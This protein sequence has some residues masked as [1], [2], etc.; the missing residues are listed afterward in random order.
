MAK[1]RKFE[2]YGLY[3]VCG[4]SPY[5]PVMYV[6]QASMG[7]RD[8]FNKH[9]YAARNDAS[10]PVSRWMRKHGVENIRYTVL[11][12]VDTGEEMDIAEE[13]WIERLGTLISEGGYNIIPGG[14]GVRG[15]THA[16]WAKSR[17]SREPTQETK[18]KIAATLRGKFTGEEAANVKTTRAQ[19]EEIISRY[20]AGE[21]LFQIQDSMG[22]A[23]STVSGVTSGQSWKYV[24]RPTTPRIVKSTGRFPPGQRPKNTKLTEEDIR[25]IRQLAATGTPFKEIGEQF[26]ITG[27]NVSMIHRRVT[28]KNVD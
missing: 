4:C 23:L 15:Y 19:V 3:C 17:I 9:T 24:P 5:E 6:G 20:W 2:V 14:A 22:L 12:S 18:D 26:G 21:T 8:R 7:A 27:G 28:W 11:E 13:A 1:K 25:S 16:P 10:W